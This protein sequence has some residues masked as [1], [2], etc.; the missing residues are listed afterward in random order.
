MV[1]WWPCQLSEQERRLVSVISREGR[2]QQL[3]RGGEGRGWAMHGGLVCQGL[4]PSQPL[5]TF[6]TCFPKASS[7]PDL[8]HVKKKKKK[9]DHCICHA[10][11]RY[12]YFPKKS[13]EAKTLRR[14]WG[15]EFLFLPAEQDGPTPIYMETLAGAQAA[16]NKHPDCSR[17]AGLPHFFKVEFVTA[18]AQHICVQGPFIS[19]ASCT[20]A[21]RRFWN[22]SHCSWVTGQ[23]MLAQP[24]Q[25]K[26]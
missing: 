10:N 21:I 17:K 4:A 26:K 20:T 2:Q 7:L 19:Q 25:I 12:L 6:S 9:K 8:C 11:V 24:A 14:S 23:A 16:I 5:Q 3:S 1:T 13:R 22:G 15:S 18:S